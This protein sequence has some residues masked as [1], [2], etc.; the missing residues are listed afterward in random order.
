MSGKFEL[1]TS[2]NSEYVFNLIASNGRVILTSETHPERRNALKGIESVRAN[3][4]LDARFEQK[5]S[6]SGQP[7]F[8]LTA[9]NGVVIGRSQMHL[10]AA[11]MERGIA[12][13]K[14]HAPEANLVDTTA[15]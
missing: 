15:Q 13:V 4:S 7:F 2:G 5:M 10:S 14:A 6:D 3:A 1:K 11:A 9:A 8:M 12:S